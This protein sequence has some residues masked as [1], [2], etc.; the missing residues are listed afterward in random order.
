MLIELL[1]Q[2]SIFPIR[3]KI[4]HSRLAISGVTGWCLSNLYTVYWGHRRC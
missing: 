2:F 3:R 4:P 1:D